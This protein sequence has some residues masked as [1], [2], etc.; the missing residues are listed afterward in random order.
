[1][2]WDIMF[3]CQV[4][5]TL[6][7]HSPAWSRGSAIS[8]YTQLPSRCLWGLLPLI[9][10]V[11]WSWK[12]SSFHRIQGVTTHL[13]TLKRRTECTT[14]LRKIP[15]IFA[16]AP[17]WPRICGTLIHLFCDFLIFSTAIGHLSSLDD[18]NLPRYLKGLILTSV[19]PYA[20]N[21]I[22]AT[23]LTASIESQSLFRSAHQSRIT[24]QE[25]RTL[26]YFQG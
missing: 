22:S 19:Y 25:W 10:R 4:I 24:V 2:Y 15:D 9:Q 20:S 17:F 13:S 1:M 18:N 26:R 6:T 14:A 3:C 12:I 5:Y 16:S 21:F 23:S 8:G 7:G 11:N